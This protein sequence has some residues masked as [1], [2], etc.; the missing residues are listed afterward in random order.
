MV[1]FA[2]DAGLHSDGVIIDTKTTFSEV[3]EVVVTPLPGAT[4]IETPVFDLATDEPGHYIYVVGPPGSPRVQMVGSAYG[5]GASKSGFIQYSRLP[6]DVGPVKIYLTESAQ[7]GS[8]LGQ[9]HWELF[10]IEDD[11]SANPSYT[12]AET[13]PP[14]LIAPLWPPSFF[15]FVFVPPPREPTLLTATA[16]EYNVPGLGKRTRTRRTTRRPCSL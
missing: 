12:F 13:V 11:E 16:K 1:L 14:E 6:E 2:A 3:I 9:Q 10:P 4:S 15:P 5:G 7:A 8:D